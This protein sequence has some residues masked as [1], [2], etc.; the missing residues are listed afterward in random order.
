MINKTVNS[1]LDEMLG[2]QESVAPE[3]TTLTSKELTQ[4]S[5]LTEE[6]FTGEEVEVAGLKTGA[7]KFIG[8]KLQEN[9]QPVK[10]SVTRKPVDPNVADIDTTL[11]PKSEV[12]SDTDA[13]QTPA[14]QPTKPAETALTKEKEEIQEVIQSTKQVTP[15]ELIEQQN[16]EAE[17]IA[18]M[19]EEGERLVPGKLAFNYE[20]LNT[21]D[22]VS[23]LI[24]ANAKLFDIKTQNITFDEVIE[25]AKDLGFSKKYINDL[26]S[27]KLE[28]DPVNAYQTNKLLKVVQNDLNEKLLRVAKGEVSPQESINIMKDI[29]FNSVLIQNAK[30]Y[31]TNIAQ[32]LAI[33]KAPVGDVVQL[34]DISSLKNTDELR[35]FAEKFINSNQETKNKLINGLAIGST[36]QKLNNIFISGLL[37]RPGTHILNIASTLSTI[38]LR[39]VNTSTAAGLDVA[40]YGFGKLVGQDVRRSVYFSEALS[41]IVAT[42]KALMNGY[43][44]LQVS[45]KNGFS[46]N[47]VDASKLETAQFN[48][49]FFDVKE[50]SPFAGLA[51]FFN[52]ATQAPGKALFLA[53]EFMKGINYTFELESH[54]TKQAIKAHDEVLLNKGTIEE[55]SAAYDNVATAIYDNPPDFI[56]DLALENVFLKPLEPGLL[57][58]IKDAGNDPTFTSLLIKTQVPFLQTPTNIYSQVFEEVPV[59]AL[60][61][62]KARADLSSGDPARI[63]MALAKQSSGAALLYLG[64]SFA[65]DGNITGPG[66]KDKAE[67]Q[68]L[69]DQGWQP[70]SIV[71]DLSFMSK[72]KRKKYDE[73]SRLVKGKGDYEG[74]YFFSY[75]GLE[76]IGALLAMGAGYADYARYEDNPDNLNSFIYGA[77]PAIGEYAVS[78]PL[79]EGIQ[80]TGQFFSQI[81]PNISEDRIDK[82]INDFIAGLGVRAYKSVVP[83]SGLQKS[84]REIT[85]PFQRDYKIN[86]DE[87]PLLAGIFQAHNKIIN[88][89]P[90]MSDSLRRKINIWNEELTYETA[91]SPLRAS[92]GKALKANEVL[93][94]T[95]TQYNKPNNR[96]EKTINGIPLSTRLTEEEY[97]EMIAI[98]NDELL[99]PDRII[100]LWEDLKEGIDIEAVK[101]TPVQ[102]K[103]VQLSLARE[104]ES[105]FS[106]ARALL[107]ERSDQIQ[108]RLIDELEEV[109]ENVI[110]SSDEFNI[111]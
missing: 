50:G 66:P 76:P 58:Q 37:S 111:R 17:K 39:M 63:Q 64:S 93:I 52:Y 11:L 34:S 75:E 91:W 2:E 84:A 32:S 1:R 94:A 82:S 35:L 38:P 83:L 51:N 21:S 77:V 78:H 57:K 16:V 81:G 72:D 44:A 102:L 23:A 80:R 99:L 4:K 30:T 62:K 20:V 95:G 18:K 71:I 101:G 3:D 27:G 24:E 86:G 6:V 103:R 15:E 26:V 14:I 87:D 88:N 40:R 41:Q 68:R 70:Y 33:M 10:K 55:A 60:A 25:S 47:A 42:K 56:H 31:K 22:D 65:T 74:K 92:K 106:D 85:D 5:N 48:V 107:V 110:Q 53:D 19:R 28:I 90:G 98:A 67:Y 96:A 9:I 45:R 61:T 54:I 12:V 36:Y 69:V 29:S 8:K 59:L 108:Q 7:M 46:K 109:D 79:L 13:I 105:V 100:S 49:D 89:V 43:E 97:R 73:D 104:M